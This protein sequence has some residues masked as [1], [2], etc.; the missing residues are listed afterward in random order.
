MDI[1]DQ[2]HGNVFMNFS[3]VSEKNNLKELFFIYKLAESARKGN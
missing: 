3:N 1:E 2:L